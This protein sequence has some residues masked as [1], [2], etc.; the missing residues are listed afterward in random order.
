MLAM[1]L[2]KVS[3]EEVFV[4]RLYSICCHDGTYLYRK[5]PGRKAGKSVTFLMTES[6]IMF[7]CYLATGVIKEAWRK[8]RKTIWRIRGTVL[9]LAGS[10]A[11]F[12]AVF[13]NQYAKEKT[14]DV[15]YN[16]L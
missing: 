6:Q 1:Y 13:D 8:R 11:V 16:I 2:K 15:G 5:K 10:M 4:G 7:G 9:I 14:G 12:L 3:C